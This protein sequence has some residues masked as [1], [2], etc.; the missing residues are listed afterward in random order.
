MKNFKF[1]FF[2]FIFLTL[3]LRQ[4]F[5]LAQESTTK[6]AAQAEPPVIFITE[7]NFIHSGDLIDIDVVGSVEYDWRGTLTPEGTIN[8]INYIQT[9]ILA[10]C[11]T[12]N[13]VAVDV[14]QAFSNFLRD[15]KIEVK[16]IDR[17]KRP[18]TV[19]Y[20]AVKMPQRF[21]IKR[22]VMLNELLVTAGGITDKASGEIQ[23]LRPPNTDCSAV[24][25]KNNKSDKEEDSK[26]ERIA[27][28][29]ENDGSKYISVKI[30]ELLAGKEEANPQIFGGDIITVLDAGLVYVIGGVENPKQVYLRSQITLSRA[31]AS[32]GGMT[33]DAVP[34][35]ITVYRREANERKTIEVDYEKIKI[36]QS[37]DLVLQPFDIIEVS[38][39]GSKKSKFQAKPETLEPIAKII[40]NL[41]LHIID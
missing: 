17:S 16:I 36:N 25:A 19:L 20:G 12:E 7:E 15:P 34:Q 10:L 4:N 18:L 28:T 22:R 40:S 23:I 41:P 29:V 9:P 6:N 38:R 31:I 27:A 33:K 5:V 32:A 13:E 30:G 14:A 37:E 11:R 24:R 26:R 1:Y 2:I 8:T 3:F 39:K 21:Q 35:K